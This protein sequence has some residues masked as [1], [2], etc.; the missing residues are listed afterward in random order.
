MNQWNRAVDVLSLFQAPG[1][2]LKKS[3]MV[4]VF[5]FF[6]PNTKWI[7]HKTSTLQCHQTWLGQEVCSW[8]HHPTKWTVFQ[9]HPTT[10]FEEG[11]WNSYE[12]II[13]VSCCAGCGPFSGQRVGDFP[14][15]LPKW[16]QGSCEVVASNP[17]HARSIYIYICMCVYYIYIYISKQIYLYIYIYI[18]KYIYIY[19]CICIY[20]Y[21]NVNVYMYICMC[22]YIYKYM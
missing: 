1:I 18:K 9:Q 14:T 16:F 19:I 5:P 4:V 7:G 15:N 12:F 10:I 2:V 17:D 21:V 20:I 3:T 22:I 13:R 8:K 6:W 11:C